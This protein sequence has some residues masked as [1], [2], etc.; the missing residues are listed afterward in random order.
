MNVNK[1]FPFAFV[2]F[3]INSVA[4][5]F[6]L[7]YTALLCPFFYA[8]VILKRKRE[9]LLPFLTILLP[10]ILMHIF[11]VGVDTISYSLSLLNVVM[12]YIFCQ[13]VYTFLKLCADPEKIFRKLLVFNFILCLVA[14]IFYFTPWFNYFWI[15][16]RLTTGVNSFRRLK[17]FTYEASYYATL[18]V[19]IFLFYLLQYFFRQ[20]II[21]NGLLLLMI[22]LPL[23]LSFSLG[24]IGC[25]MI[26][27]FVTFIIYFRRL[28]PKRRIA[29]A[30]ITTAAF[31]GVLLF[32]VILFYRHNP[33]FLR[34]IN[35]FSE[36]DSSGQGRTSDAFIIAGKLLDMKDKYW[37]IGIGQ[38]KMIGQGIIRDYYLYPAG[39]PI[40]IPNV[41]AE[42]LAI[43]GWV[44][45][46]VRIGI[47]ICLFFFTK[48]WTNYYRLL[49]FLFIFFYQFTGSFITSTAEYVIWILAFTNVFSQF[50]VKAQGKERN[51]LSIAAG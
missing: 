14:I 3:F 25:L 43:F 12:V 34:L 50:N 31:L 40:T 8:W 23:I 28:A 4:L 2:Y 35:I 48:V 17:L 26:S 49:L 42:T 39:Y 30:I 37:G 44:G 32:I 45:V 38:I 22:F 21:K 7:T 24:V 19:P 47:E 13:A 41:T 51:E 16:Q 1:Y 27:G 15:Q 36:G 6:G 20:N 9:I 46:M 18:F 33:V 29:N 10:F 5:P 11:I